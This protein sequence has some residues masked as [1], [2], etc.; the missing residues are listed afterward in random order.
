MSSSSAI[1]DLKSLI[2]SFHPLIAIETVEEARARDLLEEACYELD[3]HLF[4]WSVTRGLHR[5]EDGSTL[6]QTTTSPV[7]ALQHIEDLEVDAVFLFKDFAPHLENPA[8]ARQFRET[9][10]RLQRGMGSSLVLTGDSIALAPELEHIAIFYQL[11]LPGTEELS[12]LLSSTTKTMNSLHGVEISLDDPGKARVVNA[13][14]GMTLNQARQSLNRV[15]LRDGRLCADDV[16]GILERK[17]TMIRDGGMLEFYPY[18]GNPFELGGFENLKDWLR[19]A[20]IGFT[21]EAAAFNLAPPRGILIV[22]VQGCGKS[23]A[24]KAIARDWQVPLLKLDAGALYNKYIGE[25]ERNFRR[26]T[27]LAESVA[28]CV[29]WIDEM[30]KAFASGG[31]GDNDGGTSRRMLGSF[32]TWLQEK[33]ASVFVVGTAND[34]DCL[35]PELMRKGRFDEIFFVDLPDTHERAAIFDIHLKLRNQNP[36]AFDLAALVEASEGFS[37]AEI[38]QA[39]IASLYRA[40]YLKRPL[41]TELI[42]HELSETVPLSVSRREQISRLRADASRRFVS[43]HKSGSPPPARGLAADEGPALLA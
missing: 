27:E 26:A 14:S 20:A 34:L 5:G 29:L 42:R 15:M 18:D 9:V 3:K 32:L 39:V 22:G 8:T 35:P 38:E 30:E 21:P 23:L 2:A 31:D 12:T 33:K 24:A 17:A 41:D 19:R 11:K 1:H 36:G 43:V 37:G 4:E 10:E 40:L 6:L 16:T 7:K 13:L 28:P 25:S